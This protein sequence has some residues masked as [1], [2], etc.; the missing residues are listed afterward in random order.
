MKSVEPQ[1][2]NVICKFALMLRLFSACPIK[3]VCVL[4]TDSVEVK[5]NIYK[6]TLNL[7]GSETYLSL[8]FT[9]LQLFFILVCSSI[10]CVGNTINDEVKATHQFIKHRYSFDVYKLPLQETVAELGCIKDLL[11]CCRLL[12][13][14][15]TG[16]KSTLMPK[17]KFKFEW[18]N[19]ELLLT[20]DID[21]SNCNA[22]YVYHTVD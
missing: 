18:W 20:A 6:Q 22:L 8:V 4:C 10:Q 1:L 12:L 17:M 19:D 11:L 21:L 14:S 13:S 7:S 16:L 2:A 3:I 5:Y 15:V 9:L